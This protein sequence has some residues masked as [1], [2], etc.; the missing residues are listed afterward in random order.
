MW[1]P[2]PQR[3]GRHSTVMLEGGTSLGA[4]GCPPNAQ[5]QGHRGAAWPCLG[6]LPL[7]PAQGRV[8]LLFELD[9]GLLSRCADDLVDFCDLVQLVGSGEE[10]LQ[11]GQE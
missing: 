7:P 9:E 2:G 5:P 4:L 6:S 11:T 8:H 1:P 3:D 10:G